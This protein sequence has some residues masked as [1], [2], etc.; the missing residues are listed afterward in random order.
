MP[1]R[2]GPGSPSGLTAQ[3]RVAL[4]TGGGSGFGWRIAVSLAQ[5]GDRAVAAFRGS[6]V[7]FT[8]AAQDLEGRSADLGAPVTCLRMD[9][10]DD[11]SVNAGVQDVLD[12][13]GRIDI[14]V[15]CAGYGVLGPMECTTVDQARQLFEVNV[16]GTMRMAQAVV[17][18]MRAQGGGIILNFGSDVGVRA[19]FYQ[20]AYAASKF[21]VHGL[22]Q[23]MR[24]ELQMFGVKVAIIDPGWYG[25]EFGES[26]VS[27]FGASP[28]GPLYEAQVAAWNAGVA[29]V[30]G[31]NED[32]QEVADLVLRV[33]DEPEPSFLNVA[34][35]NPVRM[36]GVRPDE[37]DDYERRLFDYY[38]LEAFRGP[39]ARR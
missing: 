4:I 26:I 7:G 29:G 19:N 17:P 2:S 38:G 36:A 24:W 37:V 11:A 34:G 21:A 33:I 8:G 31:P 39:W 25:T 9:V 3:G 23:V 27:T 1:V 13:F 12:R 30:E 16:L 10:T 22:T 15:N 6:D 35:W 32:P 20:S 28:M 14:L 5:R 18:A